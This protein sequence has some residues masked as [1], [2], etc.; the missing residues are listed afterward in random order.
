ML[1][2]FIKTIKVRPLG[3]DLVLLT[4]EENDRLEETL[5]NLGEWTKELFVEVIPWSPN[6]IVIHRLT[7]VRC[8]GVPLHLWNWECF[9]QLVSCFGELV[10]IDEE[11]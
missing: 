1:E 5:K 9:K 10:A 11:I 2:G 4:G 8:E 7:W 6:L 3:G